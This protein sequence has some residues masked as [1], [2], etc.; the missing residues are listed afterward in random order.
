MPLYGIICHITSS[1][2]YG[3][4][5]YRLSSLSF[6]KYFFVHCRLRIYLDPSEGVCLFL[7]CRGRVALI[8]GHLG[9]PGF[10]WGRF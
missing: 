9:E 10:A 5:R 2:I 4:I 1:L 7:G 3:L 6:F 8:S